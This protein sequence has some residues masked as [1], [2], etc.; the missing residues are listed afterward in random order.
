[1][2]PISV[3]VPEAYIKAL[4]ELVKAKRYPT[5]SS[6]IRSAIRTLLLDELNLVN[7]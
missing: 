1:M 2:K 3:N 6:A 4:D 7:R 5:R